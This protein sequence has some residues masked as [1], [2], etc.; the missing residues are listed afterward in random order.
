MQA[1]HCSRLIAAF[2]QCLIYAGTALGFDVM[3][4]TKLRSLL[5]E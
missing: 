1:W 2:A 4:E 3:I 5:K